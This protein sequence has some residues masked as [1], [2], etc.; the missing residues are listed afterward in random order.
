MIN[1]KISKMRINNTCFLGVIG[2]VIMSIIPLNQ[3]RSQ[4]TDSPYRRVHIADEL[5]IPPDRKVVVQ[6]QRMHREMSDNQ[7]L[8]GV[9]LEE[10]DF[11]RAYKVHYE[12]T[13]GALV[14]EVIPNS[15]AARAGIMKNDIIMEFDDVEV[16]HAG[17][18]ERLIQGKLPGEE[19][20]VTF[21]RDGRELS[22]TVELQ[23]RESERVR[24]KKKFT[25]FSGDV[26]EGGLSFHSAFY[27]PDHHALSQLI[28]SLGFGD[29]L[30]TPQ[31][32]NFDDEGLLMQGFQVRFE[33]G[34]DW[35]WG[36]IKSDFKSNKQISVPNI[37]DQG[38]AVRRLTYEFNTFG[39]SFEKRTPFLNRIIFAPGVTGGIAHYKINIYETTRNFVWDQFDQLLQSTNN[40]YMQLR[41]NYIFIEPDMG[42]VFKLTDWLGVEGRAGYYLGYSY[43]SGWNANVVTDEYE[44]QNS[45]ETKLEGMN[46]SLGIWIDFF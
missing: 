18:L 20:E 7:S 2:I 43:H 13:Y 14:R 41:K 10:L 16:H 36:F 27:Q 6:E 12:E 45:P 38:N 28:T 35:Y 1:M 8:F 25:I 42:V 40:N 33:G 32:G 37:S 44:V 29:V 4:N 22:A 39:L 9:F 11:E 31:I 26:G 5:M 19:V 30:N 24:D 21:F 46:Y 15:P 34:N 17:H 3:L 23:E